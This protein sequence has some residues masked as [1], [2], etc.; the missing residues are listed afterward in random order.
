[1]SRPLSSV[2]PRVLPGARVRRG[3]TGLSPAAPRRPPPA[4]CR[5]AAPAPRR[6]AS[7][8][9]DC[10]PPPPLPRTARRASVSVRLSVLELSRW[11]GGRHGAGPGGPRRWRMLP[12]LAVPR[13]E[14]AKCPPKDALSASSRDRVGPRR[15]LRGR[16]GGGGGGIGEHEMGMEEG[17]V[18]RLTRPSRPTAE[19]KAFLAREEP[20]ASESPH[21]TRLG[22]SPV[23]SGP[24]RMEKRK[25]PPSPYTCVRARLCSRVRARLRV[26]RCARAC[27][28]LNILRPS[29]SRRSRLVTER[30]RRQPPGRRQSCRARVAAPKV[31]APPVRERGASHVPKR[32]L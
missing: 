25:P 7:G 8:A 13:V 27:A 17:A 23:P 18:L 26:R 15:R 21:A 5:P 28:R 12:L 11:R 22:P 9:A 4:P 10:R 30:S 3:D 19:K 31:R 6:G 2:R 29:F 1:M 20:G 16:H 24:P 14:L 32:P